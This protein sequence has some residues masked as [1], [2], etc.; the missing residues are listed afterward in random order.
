MKNQIENQ[1]GITLIALVISIIVLL[2]LAGVTIATLTGDN[3][4]LTKAGEARNTNIEAE[5]EE[6]I[7]LAWNKVYADI[8]LDKTLDKAEALKAELDKT[9][10]TDE[11]TKVTDKGTTISIEKYRGKNM[12]L[13]VSTGTVSEPLTVAKAI[14]EET[15]FEDNTP[16]TDENENT[17]IVP[18]GFKI[19]SDSSEVVTEGIVIEDA[20]YTNTKGSEFVW[21]PVSKDGT[22]ANKVKGTKNTTI[23]L[24]RYTF[25]DDG[26]PTNQGTN[27]I[28]NYYIELASSSYGNAT[29]KTDVT[30]ENGYI[31]KTNAA[32]GFWIGRYEARTTS[33][34]ARA[35]Q[36]DTLTAVTEKPGNSVYNYIK[37]PDA[38]IKSREMYSTNN[39]FESDL[40]N[41]YAWDTATLF[42]QEYDN[43]TSKPKVYSRQ[44]TVNLGSPLATGTVFEA[45]KDKICNVY[46]MASNCYEWTTETSTFSYT[47]HSVL[48][49]MS[50]IYRGGGYNGIGYWNCQRGTDEVSSAGDRYSFRPILYIK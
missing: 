48:H 33:E 12:I 16:I 29:A 23:L 45:N 39:Y 10:H 8:Y 26:T 6:E 1:K 36:N 9:G 27:T 15:I 30:S 40:I 19:S 47:R 49:V 2:I 35:S 7:R 46:D 44:Y 17:F 43:R 32:G 3:G 34:T 37:Q 24:S 41:S 25:G 11:N 5:I 42:L 20:T 13:D 38:A 4:L 31:A 18:K 14:S 22:D 28:D 21:I 50:C